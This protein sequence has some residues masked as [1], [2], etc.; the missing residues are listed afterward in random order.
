MNFHKGLNNKILGIKSKMNFHEATL[1]KS[2]AG[3]AK[4]RRS[5]AG[6]SI[7]ELLIVVAVILMLSGLGGFIGLDFYRSYVMNSE[8]D[9]LLSLLMRARNMA[10]TN[11]N[12][13]PHGVYITETAYTVF[14]GDSYASRNI[15]YD[16]TI[17]MN[18]SVAASGLHEV[19]FERLD[20]STGNSG[21]IVLS[22]KNRSI[23]V[24]LNS[25]GGI[26]W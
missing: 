9:T 6:F 25:E 17:G 11:I 2:D 4:R 22:N 3:F 23:T 26:N 24:S 10:Q 15:I 7:I 16:E 20:G 21:S 19:V 13:A 8:R 18:P 5:G 1:Q 12:Q 14:Q